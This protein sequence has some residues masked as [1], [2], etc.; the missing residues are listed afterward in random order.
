MGVL[1]KFKKEKNYLP[2]EETI[3]IIKG[4]IKNWNKTKKFLG[5]AGQKSETQKINK[6]II[7]MESAI[8]YIGE[9]KWVSQ[10]EY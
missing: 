9:N 10:K 6:I 8:H 3:T 4:E 5:L 7:A 1:G 2:K